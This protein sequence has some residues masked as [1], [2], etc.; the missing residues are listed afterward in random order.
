MEP[1]KSGWT[2]KARG[3]ARARSDS[4]GDWDNV[5]HI[6]W[7]P[8]H[9]GDT[10]SIHWSP[11]DGNLIESRPLLRGGE[12]IKIITD[13]TEWDGRIGT[14]EGPATLDNYGYVTNLEPVPGVKRDPIRLRV[15]SLDVLYIGGSRRGAAAGV[16]QS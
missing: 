14:A 4:L 7:M 2:S 11:V 5:L 10:A 1:K 15:H 13:G 9:Q 12:R 6:T 16:K 8:D 3:S